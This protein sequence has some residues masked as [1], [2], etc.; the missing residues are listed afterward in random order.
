[1]YSTGFHVP[2][3]KISKATHLERFLSISQSNPVHTFDTLSCI[4]KATLTELI[5][6]MLQI[7][8]TSSLHLFFNVLGQLT[9]TH[10]T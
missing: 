5:K 1:M 10:S 3:E 9:Q 6:W 8:E 4:Y 7:I 2:Q